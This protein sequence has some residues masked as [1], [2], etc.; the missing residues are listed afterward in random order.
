MPHHA[1]RATATLAALALLVAGAPA[2]AGPQESD[3]T[4]WLKYRTLKGTIRVRDGIGSASLGELWKEKQRKFSLEARFEVT[5]DSHD[6]YFKRIEYKGRLIGKV[7]YVAVIQG[8]TTEALQS[9][10]QAACVAEIGPEGEFTLSVDYGKE[11]YGFMLSAPARCKENRLRVKTRAA[12]V[13]IQA[14]ELFVTLAPTVE[15][16]LKGS[17][18]PKSGKSFSDSSPVLVVPNGIVGLPFEGVANWWVEMAPSDVTVE[19]CELLAVDQEG[20]VTATGEPPGGS[21]TF[22]TE[23]ASVARV[24]AQ[25]CTATI[26]ALRPGTA[27]LQVA[28]AAPGGTVSRASQELTVVRVETINEGQPV[29]K[30]AIFD[31]DLVLKSSSSLTSTVPVSAQERSSAVLLGYALSN[32]AVLT[33]RA[34]PDSVLLQGLRIGKTTLQARTGCGGPTGPVVDVEVVRCDDE[35]MKMLRE[36]MEIA[37]DGARQANRDYHRATDRADFQRAASRITSSTK[38][39]AVKTAGAIVS[40]AGAITGVT[41][42]ADAK[43]IGTLS[44]LWTAGDSVRDAARDGALLQPAGRVVLSGIKDGLKGDV[45]TGIGL[46][47]DLDSAMEAARDFG[48]DLGELMG[49]NLRLDEAARAQ[50]NFLRIIEELTA[51]IVFCTKGGEQA[52]GT[53]GG[54]PQKPGPDPKPPSKKG[55][56]KRGSST[57]SSD[58]TTPPP[59][60]GEPPPDE[61]LWD[62]PPPQ[63]GPGPLQVGLPYLPAD[64]GCSSPAGGVV[65][66]AS[67]PEASQAVILASAVAVSPD[68]IP[69]SAPADVGRGLQNLNGIIV[70]FSTGPLARGQRVIQ[71][72]LG[73]IDRME[74]A[75]TTPEASP[76]VGAAFVPELGALLGEV[77]VVEDGTKAFVKEFGSCP[78]AVQAGIS[79]LQQGPALDLGTIGSIGSKP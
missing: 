16:L 64:R 70:D 22:S 21:C 18:L 47:M 46:A 27:T 29:P 40:A 26:S 65:T 73:L 63:P 30:F 15:R 32:P 54:E 7:T 41:G 77:K 19:P 12:P 52:P 17:P 75:L 6:A 14:E 61:T 24:Q 71:G 49:T 48:A 11:T 55:Q 68:A 38:Q 37:K 69:T 8:I 1:I 44:D 62:P 79:A 23:P 34:Q 66:M 74:A 72:W 56:G 28:Y 51:K 13:E 57:P 33:A 42:G 36:Q 67:A 58:P 39:L 25:G 31:K 76:S 78:A 2:R 60:P 3:P 43:I 4:R 59:G 35:T 20:T 53:D 5:R 9:D 45:A 10:V 50:A